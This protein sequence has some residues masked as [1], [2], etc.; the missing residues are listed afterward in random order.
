MCVDDGGV[1][2]PWKG[3]PLGANLAWG[4]SKPEALCWECGAL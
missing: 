1:R 3:I 4:V 2:H